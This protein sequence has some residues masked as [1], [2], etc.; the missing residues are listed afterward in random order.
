[1]AMRNLVTGAAFCGKN[2]GISGRNRKGKEFNSLMPM[3]KFRPF[4]EPQRLAAL[5]ACEIMDTPPEPEFDEI[6]RL[7]TQFC[8]V[9]FGLVS[10]IDS[11]RQWVKANAGIE[12]SEISRADSF[13]THAIQ[14]RDSLFIDDL[15]E[16]E[17]FK[18]NPF[19]V[20]Y[21]KVRMYAGIP[22]W[23][24]DGYAL[25]TLCVLHDKPRVLSE[26]EKTYLQS[27]AMRTVAL[28]EVRRTKFELLSTQ[29]ELDRIL[30][31]LSSV[32]IIVDEDGF[33]R[34]WNVAAESI[35]GLSA[36][37]V[38]GKIFSQCPLDW[39]WDSVHKGIE[40]CKG[41]NL[42]VD[43]D[44][45]CL[46]TA[47]NP[48]RLLGLR[49]LPTQT[50][51]R[52]DGILIQGADITDRRRSEAEQREQDRKFRS[53]VDNISD[54]VFQ[55]NLKGQFTFLNLAWQ[56]ISGRPGTECLGDSLSS[57]LADEYIGSCTQ[58]LSSVARGKSPSTKF[59]C[60]LADPAHQHKWLQVYCQP[61]L[62]DPGE[63]V[64]L[65]GTI[66]DITERVMVEEAN[67]RRRRL[68]N[69]LTSLSTTFIYTTLEDAPSAIE[70][71]LKAV[72]QFLEA[73]RAALYLLN[74]SK[75][76]RLMHEFNADGTTGQTAVTEDFYLGEFPALALSLGNLE[77]VFVGD[78]HT[79]ALD[80]WREK[81][82]LLD[83]GLE[84]KLIIPLHTEGDLRG[85]L[86]FGKKCPA[87]DL[88]PDI[89][90]LL[91][92]VGLM[93]T[94]IFERVRTEEVI[95]ALSD[96]TL[97]KYRLQLQTIVT[98][99][100][101]IIFSVD[102]EGYLT[103][104]EGRGLES[105]GQQA[106]EN[107]G[108]SVFEIY[109]Q[110]VEVCSHLKRVLAG[111][112]FVAQVAINDQTL[113]THFSPIFDMNH[114][115]DGAIG[116]SV[117]ITERMVTE[118][119]IR[120]RDR[121][122]A[123][124]SH[125]IVISDAT[126]PNNP[127]V[128]AN[129]KFFKMTGYSPEE[130]YGQN[131]RFLNHQD[132]DQPSLDELRKCIKSGTQCTVTLRNYRKDGTMFLNELTLYPI[133]DADGRVTNF[134]GLQ[135]D[136]TER[137]ELE[138]QL[139]HAQKMESVGVLA[140]GIAHEIN[141]PLQYVGDNTRFLK[142]TSIC[143]ID[144]Y[145]RCK[146]LS[147][148]GIVERAEE[149]AAFISNC[150]AN[151]LI[152]DIPDALEQ[153]LEG[154]ERVTSIVQALKEFSHPGTVDYVELDIN[155]AITSTTL[156]TRNEWKYV[157]E[158]ET[159]LDPCMPLVT[160]LPGELNQVILNLIVNASHAIKGCVETKKIV[161]GLIQIS[162]RAQ[163]DWVE[164]MVTDN[165]GGV[166]K[167]I[168]NKIFDPFFTTKEV[169]TGTGQGLAICRSIIVEKHRGTIHFVP[170]RGGGTS[171]IVRIPVRWEANT[172]MSKC[173][174]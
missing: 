77:T 15:S 130:T 172:E 97:E 159:D 83:L 116:V 101:L 53:V 169:G 148:P 112:S 170:S 11:H 82:R 71:A 17:R 2:E 106:G 155:R 124:S 47:R 6:V 174:A 125:G 34:R 141:T 74:E 20:Q 62:N 146:E 117:N 93:F 65:S 143:L 142:R 126:L 135:N 110:N 151:Y 105:L 69:L 80:R 14:G 95:R 154:I 63:I 55:M 152:A 76:F 127:I 66:E 41:T 137:I 160:C 23:T 109:S 121:A 134:V 161:K 171:F 168:E 46:K 32:M 4:N 24:V 123:S 25:G 64:G 98:S 45:I 162:T 61:L 129:P 113:E 7:A 108:K 150:E 16:D 131:C 26:I 132:T 149:L 57:L 91:K 122:M 56:Q 18:S 19:V 70:F 50:R 107:V 8:G 164:I 1:M 42:P 79:L 73:D 94:N 99:A 165:G 88:S 13:C 156:V 68:E 9:K 163:G 167:S 92:V 96:R 29:Q 119:A 33:V 140:A 35:L 58:I 138:T 78:V 38:V 81:E 28:L 128:Y 115:I 67:I 136:I 59:K 153:S 144:L 157:S 40:R 48:K 10:L 54:V 5:R 114:E 145:N 85:F 21:P 31:S 44:D 60:R 89:H 173:A 43:L 51:D 90:A 133:R 39:D 118:E 36:D 104:S 75:K 49:I 12:I 30:Q 22:L 86:S 27:L 100:P 87:Q 158:L 139:A 52:T 84:S 37:L 72:C 147:G 102:R 111:E 120:L 166:P 103:L 3:Q